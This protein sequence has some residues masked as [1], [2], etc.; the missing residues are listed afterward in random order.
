MWLLNVV[1]TGLAEARGSSLQSKLDKISDSVSGQTVVD[2]KVTPF[3]YFF[4]AVV[5]LCASHTILREHSTCLHLCCLCIG[6]PDG[7]E[8]SED[9]QRGRDRR[10]QEGQSAAR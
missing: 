2:P 3:H 5:C 9:Q 8:Q 1:T 7:L 10:H 4:C 6:V